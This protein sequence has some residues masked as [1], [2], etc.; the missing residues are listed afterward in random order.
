MRGFGF[1]FGFDFGPGPSDYIIKDGCR[2][3]LYGGAERDLT[4]SGIINVV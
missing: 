2:S 1:R 3:Y 4:S